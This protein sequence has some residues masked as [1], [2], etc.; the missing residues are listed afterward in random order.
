MEQASS[1]GCNLYEST[2]APKENQEGKFYAG[3]GSV[4]VRE[5]TL[6]GLVLDQAHEKGL[7]SCLDVTGGHPKETTLVK[8]GNPPWGLAQWHRTNVEFLDFIN[9]PNGEAFLRGNGQAAWKGLRIEGRDKVHLS[10]VNVGEE[11]LPVGAVND[12]GAVRGR[13]DVHGVLRGEG[14]EN[15]G[16]CPQGNPLFVSKRARVSVQDKREELPV[17]QSTQEVGNVFKRGQ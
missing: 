10:Q 14:V 11:K 15:H 17:A 8:V 4:K 5:N 7:F 9:R 6:K 3:G 13:K 1:V 16:L 2:T 12:G